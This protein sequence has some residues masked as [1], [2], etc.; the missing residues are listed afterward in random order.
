MAEASSGN[1]GPVVATIATNADG[2]FRAVSPDFL[3][4]LGAPVEVLTGVNAVDLVHP[5]QAPVV[6]RALAT[7]N[8]VDEQDI[9]TQLFLSGTWVPVEIVVERSVGERSTWR[10]YRPVQSQGPTLL[11]DPAELTSAVTPV[12]SCD[13]IGDGAPPPTVSLL[14]QPAPVPEAALVPEAE[15]VSE[16]AL[17]SEAATIPVA[18]PVAQA[19]TIPEPA[20]VPVAGPVAQA[21]TIPEP[22]TV[23]EAEPDPGAEPDAG[24]DPD[25]EAAGLSETLTGHGQ[26]TSDDEASDT[27][28]PLPGE[29][30][31][32]FPYDD[33]DAHMAYVATMPPDSVPDTREAVRRSVG[34]ASTPMLEI[35]V[36]GRTT[37]VRG[38]W[39]DFASGDSHGADVFEN[40]IETSG[41]A[42]RILQAIEDVF[43]TAEP[44]NHEISRPLS[45]TH[46]VRVVPIPSPH[47]AGAVHALVAV[48]D[49]SAIETATYVVVAAPSGH[50]SDTDQVPGA[51]SASLVGHSK[52]G[53]PEQ[54][55]LPTPDA[56]R[57]DQVSPKPPPADESAQVTARPAKVRRRTIFAVMA[58]LAG[59]VFL[60]FASM[61]GDDAATEPVSVNL[62]ETE[63]EQLNETQT[64]QTIGAESLGELQ[65][66]ATTPD[67]G[68]VA[69]VN[70]R[71]VRL[72]TRGV[73]VDVISVSEEEE[74]V[75]TDIDA[76]DAGVLWVLDAG[77]GRVSRV[78]TDGI[79]SA[80]ATNPVLLNARGAGVGLDDTLFVASTAAAQLVHLGADG[81][82]I[83]S[84]AVPGRQPSDVAQAA[85]GTL[86]IVDAE[87][88]ELVHL[89]ED[90]DLIGALALESFS[91]LTS[92]HLSL[93]GNVLWV[94]APESSA[95][96]AI[97]TA[98]GQPTGERIELKRP[99]GSPVSK[100]VGIASTDDGELWIP[101]STG[102]AII[103]VTS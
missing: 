36:A 99:D 92:P 49:Q 100:P 81:E 70:G 77:L 90:G 14:P 63:P 25:P 85:D 93:V 62:V 102:G 82:F 86:W 67:G 50:K 88:L 20:T 12:E 19:A 80:I 22:A 103:L 17:V 10:L 48:V 1:R 43:E 40:L 11:H 46:W 53:E 98:T 38:A 84:I 59:V 6:R 27:A 44:S 41:Q 64:W 35:D 29:S 32:E 24:A 13:V 23:R 31:N 8:T 101:D 66:V 34:D 61:A 7:A 28:A 89:T 47:L 9:V 55:T 87:Q 37:F 26:A 16:A 75:V 79:V 73:A 83:G 65:S 33:S 97:D 78:A 71:L 94:T 42:D 72:D 5:L 21:A 2:W 68:F 18:G 45:P 56:S 52:D 51:P 3:T 91:S 30:G 74:V 95:V 4:M 58:I 39:N 76:D 96:F 60:I 69:D 54:V 57:S 15:T